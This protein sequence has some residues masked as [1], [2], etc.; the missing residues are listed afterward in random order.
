[1]ERLL[2][3]DG[4]KPPLD[5]GKSTDFFVHSHSPWAKLKRGWHGLELRE[6]NTEWEAL[7]RDAGKWLLGVLCQDIPQYSSSHFS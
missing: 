6:E 2:T 3:Q 7:G 5:W 1:M 4:Q